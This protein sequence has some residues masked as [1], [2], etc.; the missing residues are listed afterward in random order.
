METDGTNEKAKE[1]EISTFEWEAQPSTEEKAGG[2]QHAHF[3]GEVTEEESQEAP[4]D[5]VVRMLLWSAD[6]V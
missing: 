4:P 5:F 6:Q 3:K 2:G 1:G